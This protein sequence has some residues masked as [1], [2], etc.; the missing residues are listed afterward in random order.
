MHL[1][2]YTTLETICVG[3]DKQEAFRYA[4]P[5]ALRSVSPAREMR[6]A[7]AVDHSGGAQPPEDSF[8]LNN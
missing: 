8:D 3:L 5:L 7:A 4:V 2:I 6:H 1:T